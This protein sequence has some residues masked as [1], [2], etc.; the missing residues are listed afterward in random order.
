MR[1]SFSQ[2]IS[3]NPERLEKHA[4]RFLQQGRET[5]SRNEK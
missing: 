3:E 2:E 1:H 5:D 4:L